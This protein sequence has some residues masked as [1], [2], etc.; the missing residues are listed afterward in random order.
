MKSI[1]NTLPNRCDCMSIC[2]NRITINREWSER[3]GGISCRKLLAG[4][5]H[6]ESRYDGLREDSRFQAVL[7][8]LET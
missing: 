4:D 5:L 3:V 7:A 8:S 6:S 2:I 1:R